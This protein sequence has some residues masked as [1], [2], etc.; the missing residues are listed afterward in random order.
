MWY[1]RK[2]VYDLSYLKYQDISGYLDYWN[3]N[4][5][6]PVNSSE[7]V[8]IKDN[9]DIIQEYVDYYEI[10]YN[11]IDLESKN[12][13]ACS[14]SIAFSIILTILTIAIEAVIL[15]RILSDDYFHES[16]LCLINRFIEYISAKENLKNDKK[17]FLE[18]T[19]ELL[20]LI[21]Q[22][23]ELRNVFN[24]EAS[25]YSYLFEDYGIKLPKETL[26]STTKKK[27]LGGK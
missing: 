21:G 8:N 4:A 23:D 12:V 5:T 22:N 1:R 13:E 7:I 24:Q 11:I 17:L 14:N 6:V 10:V 26:D 3:S 18:Q 19:K 25:K 20:T 27:L 15:W 16:K 9:G 2:I